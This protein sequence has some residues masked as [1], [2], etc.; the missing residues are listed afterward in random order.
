MDE[1]KL[2]SIREKLNEY[3]SWPTVYLYKFI[4]PSDNERIA[5]VEALFDSRTAEI[6]QTPSRNGTY[7]SISA[8]EVVTSADQVIETYKRA[9]KIDGIISL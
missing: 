6:R 4:V 2:N 8:R 9:S 7:T 1:E 5:Q 3:H